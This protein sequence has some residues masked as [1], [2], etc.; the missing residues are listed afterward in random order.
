MPVFKLIVLCYNECMTDE[1]MEIIERS[2]MLSPPTEEDELVAKRIIAEAMRHGGLKKFVPESDP[3]KEVTYADYLGTMLWDGV[4]NGFVM[5]SDGTKFEI[6]A[7]KE[8]LSLVKVLS[9]HMDGPVN[10]NTPVG[11]VNFFKVYIG[12]DTDKL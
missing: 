10:P 6:E 2:E 12:I 3:R 9:N 4:V 5:F 1:N 7:T 11:N 8:W